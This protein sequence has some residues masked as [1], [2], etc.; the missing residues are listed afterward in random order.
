MASVSGKAE[1]G[2]PSFSAHVREQYGEALMEPQELTVLDLQEMEACNFV[3]AIPGPQ[4]PVV[5][6]SS[7][8]GRVS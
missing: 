4:L 7:L 3:V 6:T 5:F 2:L 8:D 1:K